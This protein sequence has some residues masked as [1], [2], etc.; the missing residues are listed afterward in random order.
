MVLNEMRWYMTTLIWIWHELIRKCKTLPTIWFSFLINLPYRSHFPGFWYTSLMLQSILRIPVNI[1]IEL[2]ETI[3]LNTQYIFNICIANIAQGIQTSIT[4]RG[5]QW[6]YLLDPQVY[7]GAQL[8]LDILNAFKKTWIIFGIF[9]NLS[10]LRYHVIIVMIY[11][12][13]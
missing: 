6:G 2:F 8:I 9:Y 3:I 1:S 10:I 13:H 4:I 11:W 12:Q 5:A 7:I